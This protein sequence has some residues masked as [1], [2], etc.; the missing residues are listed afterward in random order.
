MDL[1]ANYDV[2]LG[3]AVKLRFLFNIYNLLDQ[4]NE[5]SVNTETGRAYTAIIRETDIAIHRSD[6]NAYIDRIHDPSA[7]E[8]PRLI[9]FGVGL[10]F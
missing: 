4:L 9:K 3:K 2:D 5:I 6:F 1:R 8:A 10:V 7:Y